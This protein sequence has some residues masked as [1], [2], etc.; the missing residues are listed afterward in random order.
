M[1]DYAER[2][3]SPQSPSFSQLR[4][5]R[6]SSRSSS[7]FPHQMCRLSFMAFKT[8]VLYTF[9]SLKFSTRFRFIM[10]EWKR[11]PSLCL[12]STAILKYPSPHMLRPQYTFAPG[13]KCLVP[14]NGFRSGP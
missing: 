9:S 7:E 11:P 6:I 2:K 12:P 5:P 13:P 4:Y 3:S 1:S 10:T 14:R 8:P